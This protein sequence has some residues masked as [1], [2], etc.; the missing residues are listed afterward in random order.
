MPLVR[1]WLLILIAILWIATCVSSP[2]YLST[3]DTTDAKRIVQERAIRIVGFSWGVFYVYHHTHGNPYL[4]AGTVLRS[5]TAK[6]FESLPAT[7]K[8]EDTWMGFSWTGHGRVQSAVYDELS[9]W[10]IPLW[11]ITLAAAWFALG[12][13]SQSPQGLCHVCGYSLTGNISGVCPECGTA[14]PNKAG[15]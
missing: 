15:A 14:V 11:S 13:A 2:V 9:Q 12:R 10:S 4:P 5:K 1:R 7:T 3:T 8:F 6:G